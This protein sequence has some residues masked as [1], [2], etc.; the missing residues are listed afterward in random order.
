VSRVI[1]KVMPGSMGGGWRRARRPRWWRWAPASETPGTS[2]ATYRR[3]APRQPPTLL[4]WGNS[5]RH[6]SRIDNYVRERLALFDSKKRGKHG[7]RWGRAHEFAWFGKLGLFT[8]S[9]TVRYFGA[10]TATT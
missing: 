4:R 1:E 10:A 9:G 7:R 2:A 3:T 6:F 5:S 8:L